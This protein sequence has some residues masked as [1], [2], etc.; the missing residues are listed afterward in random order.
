MSLDT[1][2]ALAIALIRRK[3]KSTDTL[4]ESRTD[5]GLTEL[6]ESARKELSPAHIQ[7]LQYVISCQHSPT[8]FHQLLLKNIIYE[9]NPSQFEFSQTLA[10]LSHLCGLQP[11]KISISVT[12]E[13]IRLSIVAV[14]MCLGTLCQVSNRQMK[15][16]PGGSFAIL[17]YK[18]RHL[19]S[20][21]IDTLIN[22]VRLVPHSELP[23]MEDWIVQCRGNAASMIG[24]GSDPISIEVLNE[25]MCI[26]DLDN[27]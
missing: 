17:T 8:N 15:E 4:R 2:C 10:L 6:F 11:S 25:I 23:E 26:S 19:T 22:L 27:A 13:H 7:N 21:F 18:A 9:D 24:S 20:F 12:E 1:V 3:N 16:N 14:G 5:D